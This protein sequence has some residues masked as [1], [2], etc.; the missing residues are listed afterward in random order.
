MTKQNQIQT[1]AN[2]EYVVNYE[3]TLQEILVEIVP[4]MVEENEESVEGAWWM[5]VEVL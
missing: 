2:A 3:K 1:G 5:E 4:T